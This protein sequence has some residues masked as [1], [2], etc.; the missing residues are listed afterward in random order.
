VEAQA[1]VERIIWVYVAKG[2]LLDLRTSKERARTAGRVVR[3]GGGMWGGG[4]ESKTARLHGCEHSTI[5]VRL[6]H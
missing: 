5:D 1:R 4:C 6:P 3:G 2:L